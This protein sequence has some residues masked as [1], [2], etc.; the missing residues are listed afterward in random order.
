M[1]FYTYHNEIL[2]KELFTNFASLLYIS[3]YHFIYSLRTSYMYA[4]FFDQ[5]RDLSTLQ[6]PPEP[7]IMSYC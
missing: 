3:I 6:L 2:P 1:T 4:V 7:P 5:I